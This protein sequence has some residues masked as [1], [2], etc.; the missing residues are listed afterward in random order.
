MAYSVWEF[1]MLQS[2]SS[3][4]LYFNIFS[5]FLQSRK[6]VKGSKEFEDCCNAVSSLVICQEYSSMKMK[7]YEDQF[8]NVLISETRKFYHEEAIEQFTKLNIAQ[9]MEYVNC[10]LD[11]SAMRD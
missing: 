6:G 3:S 9:Y 7:L 4:S 11:V 8:E 10:F 2:K 1:G 5:V